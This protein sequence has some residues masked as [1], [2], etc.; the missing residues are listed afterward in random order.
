MVNIVKNPPKIPTPPGGTAFQSG[1]SSRSG[2]SESQPALRAD[3]RPRAPA[4]V[5]PASQARPAPAAVPLPHKFRHLNH[6][7][8]QLNHTLHQRDEAGGVHEKAGEDRPRGDARRDCIEISQTPRVGRA[9][10]PAVLDDDG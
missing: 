6:T 5:V 8:H 4:Q 2:P 1:A 9:D 7:P 3:I 10:H